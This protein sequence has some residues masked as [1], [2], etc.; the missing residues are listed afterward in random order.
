MAKV[1]EE[2][3]DLII[4]TSDNP[5]TEDPDKIIADIVAGFEDPNSDKIRIEPDRKK[6]ISYAVETAQ[7]ND[8]VLI[9][10]KGHETYQIIGKE[11][12]EFSDKKV[13]QQALQARQ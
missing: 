12:F 9:A 6:A 2:M 4:I 1:A 7:S 10:G 11:K 3:A 13:A 5:R 8:I